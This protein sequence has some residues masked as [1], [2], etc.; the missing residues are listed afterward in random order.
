VAAG[1]REDLVRR[2]RQRKPRDRRWRRCRFRHPD[3]GAGADLL[4]L[5]ESFRRSI[6]RRSSE[7]IAPFIGERRR[8]DDRAPLTVLGCHRKN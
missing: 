8:G 2:Q 7:R 1:V 5:D 3:N 4:V 6:P